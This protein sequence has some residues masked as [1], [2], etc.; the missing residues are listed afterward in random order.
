MI[1]LFSDAGKCYISYPQKFLAYMIEK[2]DSAIQ[3]QNLIDLIRILPTK[4]SNKYSDL[5]AR[6]IPYLLFEDTFYSSYYL[7][8]IEKSKGVIPMISHSKIPIF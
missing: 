4:R 8:L 5:R 6:K 1:E 3:I 7:D 2:T